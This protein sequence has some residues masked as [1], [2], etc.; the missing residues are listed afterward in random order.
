[1]TNSTRSR[2]NYNSSCSQLKL[3]NTCYVLHSSPTLIS[4]SCLDQNN[5]YTL[6]GSGRC[7]MFDNRDDGKLMQTALSEP[8]ITFSGTLGSDGL[9][10]LDTLKSTSCKHTFLATHTSMLKLKVLHQALGH[11]NYQT[12]I[13]VIQKGTIC[14]A[15]LT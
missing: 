3:T 10:H 2:E 4:I 12:L 8:S 15:N 5:C 9:Y 14:G 7:V 13:S 6:F 11:I 1:M